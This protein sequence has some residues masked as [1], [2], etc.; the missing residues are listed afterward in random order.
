MQSVLLPGF[1]AAAIAYL[2]CSLNFAIPVTR[3]FTGKDIRTM[4]S[5]NA[6]MTNVLRSVGKGAAALT[7]AG[8]VLKGTLAVFIGRWIFANYTPALPV[9]GMYVA[10]LFAILGHAFPLYFGFR[11]GKGVAVAAGSVALIDP[12]Y[13][14][15]LLGA[16]VLI[17]LLSRYISLGSVLTAALYPLGTFLRA[18]GLGQNP[19]VV[20]VFAVFMG[21]L[22]IWFHRSNIQRLLAGTERKLGEKKPPEKSA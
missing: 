13:T 2:L 9:Y 15:I 3:L 6:G 4:G 12:L 5:G 1:A 8:D 16:F 19:L 18:V 11:G 17:V 20:T 22:V 21:A 14:V 10:A 7:F